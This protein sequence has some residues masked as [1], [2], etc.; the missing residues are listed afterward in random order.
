M[1]NRSVVL[2]PGWDSQPGKRE[3]IFAIKVEKKKDSNISESVN[4]TRR[5]TLMLGIA[6]VMCSWQQGLCYVGNIP[7][8]HENM[9]VWVRYKPGIHDCDCKI[10]VWHTNTWTRYRS[11]T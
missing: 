3:A 10:K 8:D 9:V 11:H 5:S 4:H 6:V 1:G 2:K 7:M